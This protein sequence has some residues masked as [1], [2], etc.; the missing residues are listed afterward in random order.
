MGAKKGRTEEGRLPVRPGGGGNETCRDAADFF[1]R[2]RMCVIGY[3]SVTRLHSFC[4]L[5]LLSSPTIFMLV[6][7]AKTVPAIVDEARHFFES[8]IAL[9]K[10]GWNDDFRKDRIE[11]PTMRAPMWW[12]ITRHRRVYCLPTAQA[13]NACKP[14]DF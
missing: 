3:R 13:L 14:F 7:I 2:H 1:R 11:L 5:A 4:F 6:S 8:A 12:R 10:C 9:E